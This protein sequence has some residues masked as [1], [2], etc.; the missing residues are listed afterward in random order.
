M[1][2]RSEL[3]NDAKLPACPAFVLLFRSSLSFTSVASELFYLGW[4]G[5]GY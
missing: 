3:G 4:A 1:A 5:L 2:G